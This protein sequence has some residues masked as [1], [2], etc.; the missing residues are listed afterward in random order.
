MTTFWEGRDAKVGF[1]DFCRLTRWIRSASQLTRLST[2]GI[3]LLLRVERL[4]AGREGGPRERPGGETV[5]ADSEGTSREN[6]VATTRERRG[7]GS[8]K[9]RVGPSYVS[10]L[11]SSHALASSCSS[12][13]HLEMDESG[14]VQW[15]LL[16]FCRSLREPQALSKGS[17]DAVM[18]VLATCGVREQ[19]QERRGSR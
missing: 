10:T 13:M 18:Y 8:Q 11:S 5:L 12:K 6:R 4:Q 2:V 19:P 14:A 17:S 3:W 15:R 1:V 9:E 16:W 7:G